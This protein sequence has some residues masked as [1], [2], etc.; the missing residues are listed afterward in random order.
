M[1]HRI[2]KVRKGLQDHLVQPSTNRSNFLYGQAGCLVAPMSKV[3]KTDEDNDSSNPVVRFSLLCI[4][5]HY[6]FIYCYLC[7]K[8]IF[9]HRVFY[10]H[11]NRSKRSAVH[12]KG[13]TLTR[14]FSH[15]NILT[16]FV[17]NSTQK[18][19][20]YFGED[21]VR[22]YNSLWFKLDKNQI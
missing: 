14:S 19:R 10:L 7:C 5:F 17:W 20:Q 4:Y 18:L 8:N 22:V 13:I 2:T 9:P 15:I 12:C 11:A 3:T 16:V 1:N 6:C 21:R